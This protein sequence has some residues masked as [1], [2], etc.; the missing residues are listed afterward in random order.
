[1]NKRDINATQAHLYL[2]MTK[3]LIHAILDYR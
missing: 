3:C 1:M 2:D